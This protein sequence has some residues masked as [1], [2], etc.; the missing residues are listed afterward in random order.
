MSESDGHRRQSIE[1]PSVMKGIIKRGKDK[2]NGAEFTIK[3]RSEERSKLKKI[4]NLKKLNGY[5]T[6]GKMNKQHHQYI[7]F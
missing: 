1:L 4:V 5:P 7:A 2:A 6:P 3:D